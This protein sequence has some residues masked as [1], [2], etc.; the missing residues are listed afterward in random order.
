MPADFG[1]SLIGCSMLQP[2]IARVRRVA[3]GDGAVR[4]NSIVFDAPRLK[5]GARLG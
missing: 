4:A 2:M 1:F 3:D 5:V